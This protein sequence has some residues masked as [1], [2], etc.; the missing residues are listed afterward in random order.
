M[1]WENVKPNKEDIDELIGLM[2][3]V[4]QKEKEMSGESV[5]LAPCPFCGAKMNWNKPFQEPPYLTCSA[6][7]SSFKFIDITDGEQFNDAYCW[8]EISSLREALT[9]ETERGEKADTELGNLDAEIIVLKGENAELRRH[10]DALA[11]ALN[12]AWPTSLALT[13][14][15]QFREKEGG[16]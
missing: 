6:R 12:N 2:K 7:C 15:E 10:A 11:A 3:A 16:K 1:T 8:K 14:Y 4:E 9:K 13:L 5:K